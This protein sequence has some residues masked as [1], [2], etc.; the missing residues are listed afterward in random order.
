MTGERFS[1][2]PAQRE[3]IS[4][5][6][7]QSDGNSRAV[8]EFHRRWLLSFHPPPT[9]GGGW[10]TGDTA[11][12][13]APMILERLL[14][15]IS[16]DLEPIRQLARRLAKEGQKE[17]AHAVAMGPRPLVG[18]EAYAV[19]FYA[20]ITLEA[21]ERYQD[22]L[23]VAVAPFYKSLLTQISGLH[24]F[25]FA[26]F[27]I[28]A[29]MTLEPPL[30]DRSSVQPYDIAAA[31][32]H[33]KRDYAI[34]RSHPP[35]TPGGGW[36]TQTTMNRTP[37]IWLYRCIRDLLI[38]P[39]H[40]RTAKRGCFR[41]LPTEGESRPPTPRS[42]DRTGRGPRFGGQPTVGCRFG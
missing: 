15:G 5:N 38:F 18:P 9:P 11:G 30:L 14:D 31:N 39:Q 20:P 42:Q 23:S 24:A 26:L 25:E 16:E 32:K 8:N 40:A 33:W 19:Y 4:R 35:P 13:G 3:S 21:I 17:F 1:R 34:R 10:S 12:S 37:P 29:S 27:G 7:Q 41:V 36:D 28:P 6:V 22:R 2:S